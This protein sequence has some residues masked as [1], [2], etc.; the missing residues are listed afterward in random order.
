MSSEFSRAPSAL[1]RAQPSVQPWPLRRHIPPGRHCRY[2][3]R[4]PPGRHGEGGGLRLSGRCSSPPIHLGPARPRCPLAP[5]ATVR[6]GCAH[7]SLGRRRRAR[8]RVRRSRRR[9][10]AT[11]R[12]GRRSASLG[13]T[14]AEQCGPASGLRGC[15]CKLASWGDRTNAEGSHDASQLITNS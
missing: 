15:G 12:P 7:G 4:Q 3:V 9:C 11:P 8:S 5:A 1:V 6:N 14:R 10:Q 2:H 13:R